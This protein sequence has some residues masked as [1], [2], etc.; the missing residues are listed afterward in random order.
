MA[1]IAKQTQELKELHARALEEFNEIYTACWDERK[2]CIEDREFATLPGRM[3]AGSLEEQFE[4]KPKFEV[5]KVALACQRIVSE[6]RN[7]RIDADFVSK[8]GSDAGRLAD[9]C[10]ALLRADMQDS[11]ADEA[12]DNAF[13]EAVYGGI[14]AYRLTSKYEN[15]TDDEDERQRVCWETITDADSTVFFDLN[16]KRQDKSDAKVCYVLVPYTRSAYKT[17][18]GEDPTDWPDTLKNEWGDFGWL[19][20]DTVYVAE[21]Y[22]VEEKTE[23]MRVYRGPLGEEIK[24]S[25]DDFEE[26][27]QLEM[28][29]KAQGYREIRSKKIKERKVRKVI[30]SGSKVLEDCGHIAGKHIPVVVVFGKRWFVSGVERYCGH[31]RNAKDP[32]RLMNMQR[33]KLAEIAALSSVEIP[34]LTPEQVARHATMWEHA[35]V[36]N[37]PYLLLDPVTDP[38]SGQTLIGSNAIGYTKV[39]NIPPATVAIMQFSEQ[40]IKDV[41]GN[42][43]AGEQIQANVS[44][45]AIQR[46]Q[47]R[48]DMQT[49]IYVSNMAKAVKRA[50]EI[51]LSL[52]Q[53][54]YTEDGRKMKGIGRDEKLSVVELNKK[55]MR[56]GT[57]V[58]DN[59][60]SSAHF[61]ITA[62]TGPSSNTKKQST[63]RALTG[64]IG[65]TSDPETQQVISALMMLNMEGEGLE[66]TKPYWRNRLLKMGAMKPTEE[67][68]QAM[69]QAQ[70][71]QQPDANT[72]YLQAAAQ[73]ATANALKKQAETALTMTKVDE[74]RANTLKTLS[75]VDLS[76]SQAVIDAVTQ[77]QPTAPAAP[78]VVAVQPPNI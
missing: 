66:D 19:T 13:D 40:D 39:P 2:Q 16:S 21:R 38:V 60:I 69:A 71:N 14:G 64:V 6:Y 76:R 27:D 68:A 61:D 10:D 73:D 46:V 1:K 57:E 5:N 11:N 49:F 44:G 18:W 70:A 78:D 9:T 48:M 52:A 67:E 51:W 35:N 37:W 54:L 45:E 28:T 20:P 56:D 25:E 15:E 8:D 43:E 58:K 74:T 30:M 36:K 26:D 47:D 12:M 55:M 31:V 41:L 33:S 4:N 42:P 53:E 22:E 75:D 63:I 77:L 7:S 65:A 59:D 29:L 50:A 62:V 34:I 72:Q 24:H 23:I 32:Q 17:E 3:W